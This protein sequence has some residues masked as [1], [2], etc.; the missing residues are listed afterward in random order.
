MREDKGV[1]ASAIIK[2]VI[3]S[4]VAVTLIAILSSALIFN[5]GWSLFDYGISIDGTNISIFGGYVYDDPETYKVGNAQYTENVQ[6][7]NIDWASGSVIL[8]VYEG[9]EVKVEE[10]ASI[11]NDADRMRTRI[12]DDTLDIKYARSGI[13]WGSSGPSKQLN[14]YIPKTMASSLGNICINA[15][16]A[17]VLISDS[18]DVG[19]S[20]TCNKLELVCI[21]GRMEIYGATAAKTELQGVSSN[22]TFRGNTKELSMETVSGS[23]NALGEIGEV[24]VESVSGKVDLNLSNVPS[25]ITVDAV[26]GNTYISIPLEDGGF[27]ARLDSLGGSIRVN[28]SIVGKYYRYG[29]AEA[30]F[31]FDAVSGNVSIDVK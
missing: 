17:D 22:I 3:W 4:M 8:K 10:S 31:E 15:A 5:K 24:E 21:S 28:G 25:R 20:I 23:L 26:S 30:K 9:S 13:R 6:N 7:I 11:S 1:R 2:L 18:S 29:D 19:N 16:S 27:D 14:V 12:K